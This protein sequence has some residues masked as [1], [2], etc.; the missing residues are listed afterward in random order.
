MI[1]GIHEETQVGSKLVVTVVVVAFDRRVLDRAVHPLDL[2][3]GP[4]VAHLGQ[5]M[6]DPMLV[7]HAVE[8]V[9][10]LVSISTTGRKPYAVVGQYRM[11][12]I[13]HDFDEVAQELCGFHLAG[14]V[15]KTN[16]LVRSMATNRRS[17]PSAVL[18]S[19]L[20]MRT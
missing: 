6:C 2:S 10:T 16:L 14:A 15:D 20:S 5:T 3:V 18:T 11:D 12:M 17:L 7:T 13:R 19:A 1:V 8:A 9:S 4:R